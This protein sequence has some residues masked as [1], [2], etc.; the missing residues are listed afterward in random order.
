MSQLVAEL[1]LHIALAQLPTPATELR[2]HPKRR[3]RFDLAWIPQRL[4]CEVEGGIWVGG[5]H[6]RGKGFE[7]DC[8]KYA[9]ALLLGW[10]VLRV[11]GG[12][13]SDGRALHLVERALREL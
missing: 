11:T 10:R 6:T 9:E 3:W 2:F 7:A 12:M 13:I 8:E 5:R 4:A 1:Q